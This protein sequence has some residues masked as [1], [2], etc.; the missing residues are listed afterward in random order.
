MA[1]NKDITRPNENH[2]ST[3]GKEKDR[4]PLPD[5]ARQKMFVN[6]WANVGVAEY[7]GTRA[8]LESEGVIPVDFEWPRSAMNCFWQV[9]NLNFSLNR[10]RPP[11][12]KGPMKLWT[13]GDWWQFRWT[14]EGKYKNWGAKRIKQKSV[15]LAREIYLQS[16]QGIDE[17]NLHVSRYFAACR[18]KQF[19]AFKE[20]IPA[21]QNKKAAKRILEN[22]IDI[23]ITESNRKKRQ[24][25]K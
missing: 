20:L 11:G 6:A 14:P 24:E 9:G 13:T 18:D 8:Q 7:Q 16:K 17:H 23:A 1:D 2:T 15:E 21:L 12:L 5:P 25:V 4:N 3:L 22:T 19:Q 10:C